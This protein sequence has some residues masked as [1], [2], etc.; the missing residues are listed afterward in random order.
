M[1]TIVYPRFNL[2]C[3]RQYSPFLPSGAGIGRVPPSVVPA[4]STLRPTGLPKALLSSIRAN[5]RECTA[6]VSALQTLPTAAAA[7]PPSTS[8]VP[9]PPP[10][11]FS[12]RPTFAFPPPP[13]S[14]RWRPMPPSPAYMSWPARP[15]FAP[16]IGFQKPVLTLSNDFGCFL[17]ADGV[18]GCQVPCLHVLLSMQTIHE[19]DAQ[20]VAVKPIALVYTFPEKHP[21]FEYPSSRTGCSPA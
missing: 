13:P 21:L 14:R 19:H 20:I 16:L 8:L 6:V 18:A 15:A 17:T 10:S 2:A 9:R 4:A 3:H 7:G 1:F 12:R 11:C 5:L